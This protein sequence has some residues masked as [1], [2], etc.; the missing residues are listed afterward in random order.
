MEAACDVGA[1]DDAEHGVVVAESPDA[2]AL[3]QVGVQVDAGHVASLVAEKRLSRAI[4]GSLTVHEPPAAT[5]GDPGVV[6]G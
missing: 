6:G 1:G 3:A 4:P 5:P 2:E